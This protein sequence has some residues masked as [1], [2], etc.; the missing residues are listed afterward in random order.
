MLKARS[1][2]FVRAGATRLIV[3]AMLAF[4]GVAVYAAIAEYRTTQQEEMIAQK[5]RPFAV[6]GVLEYCGPLASRIPKS[7]QARFPL[8][9]RIKRVWVQ[10]RS[11][12]TTP[13]L[14]PMIERKYLNQLTSLEFIEVGCSG[15][16]AQELAM[17]RQSLPDCKIQ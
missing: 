15:I 13:N 8:F 5:L 17:L 10:H 4:F 2:H 14:I 3:G 9:R 12:A 6:Y 1:W 16:T 11:Y 7:T